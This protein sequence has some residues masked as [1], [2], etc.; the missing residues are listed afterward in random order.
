MGTVGYF[1]KIEVSEDL[2]DWTALPIV[3]EGFDE[4]IEWGFAVNKDRFFYRLRICSLFAEDGN[5]IIL[6]GGVTFIGEPEMRGFFENGND[7][8]LDINKG[9]VFSTGIAADW[10]KKGHP[11]NEDHN[12]DGDAD[13]EHWMRNHGFEDESGLS[14]KVY[15]SHDAS[16]VIIDFEVKP[17]IENGSVNL[18]FLFAS[19]EYYMPPSSIAPG[20]NAMND[21][22]AIF[23]FRLDNNNE[24]IPET[25]KNLALLPQTETHSRAINVYNAGE[26]SDPDRSTNVLV[27]EFVNNSP[28][29]DD[30][31][32]N[33]EVP[34][35]ELG[36]SG[37]TG[38]MIASGGPARIDDDVEIIS[39][40]RQGNTTIGSQDMG[41]GGIVFRGSH[42]LEDK[43]NGYIVGFGLDEGDVA[44]TLYKVEDHDAGPEGGPAIMPNDGHPNFPSQ[45]V[46]VLK[47][48]NV[49]NFDINDW[50]WIKVDVEG[51]MIRAR[52]WK[53][54]ESEPGNWAI[55][56]EDLANPPLVS[57]FSGIANLGTTLEN[58]FQA[59]MFSVEAETLYATNFEDDQ[60]GSRIPDD[61]STIGLHAAAAWNVNEESGVPGGKYVQYSD[62]TN[63]VAVLRLEGD[64]RLEGGKR[65]R[66]KIVVADA[67][68]DGFWD[69]AIFIKQASFNIIPDY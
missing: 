25:R 30:H 13:L 35:Y 68:S 40:V 61:W 5:M 58:Q 59:A 26:I 65:Y 63:S 23:F 9:F 43:L 36:Y 69:S 66:V 44:F 32:S 60:T 67:G 53:D 17:N 15:K 3:E 39:L 19:D 47:S 55:E 12:L 57:G 14:G 62:N 34:P 46:S 28:F 22:M 2:L 51:N 21:A 48:V 45:S 41:W 37:F 42:S 20:P 27:S 33:G 18:E 7:H 11:Q 8:G 49:T 56:H 31:D 54:G 1:Y 4:P 29:E 24:V 52:F 64:E 38:K 6:P 16:G 10:N 50:Y